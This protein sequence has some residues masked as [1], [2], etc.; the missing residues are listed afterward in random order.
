MDTLSV[1]ILNPK[2]KKLLQD[3]ADMDLI[4]IRSCSKSK[5]AETLEKLRSKND[6]ELTLEEITAEVEL[7]RAER[8]AKAKV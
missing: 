4:A 8:Y 6:G 7:V 1:D 5:F 2:A 3:L